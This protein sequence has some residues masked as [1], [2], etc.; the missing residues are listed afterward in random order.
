M[1]KLKIIDKVYESDMI[2]L[3][4][5]YE[6]MNFTSWNYPIECYGFGCCNIYEVLTHIR[7]R[8]LTDSNHPNFRIIIDDF[9]KTENTKKI[10]N[11]D[12]IF[13]IAKAAQK[14][15]IEV[16]IHINNKLN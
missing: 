13:K 15:G 7:F 5:A 1:K 9:Y 2:Y 3:Q 11:S 6:T 14:A 16:R 4:I 8:Q 12:H 10:N